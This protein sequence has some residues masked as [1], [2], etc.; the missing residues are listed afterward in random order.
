MNRL[1][2]RTTLAAIC[3]VAV[4]G[5]AIA[6]EPASL[7]TVR[8]FE[9]AF[10]AVSE[11][12]Q[13]SVVLLEVH[14]STTG[15]VRSLP[16]ADFFPVEGLGSGFIIDD[17]GT[18]LTNHHVIEGADRIDVTLH[19]GRQLRAVPVAS[20]PESDVGVVRLVDPPS[21]LPVAELGDSG[22]LRI[23]QFAIAVGAPLGY[24]RSVTYGHISGLHRT[25]VGQHQMGP[26]AAPGFESLII[27]DFIQVDTPI[28]PG[29]S[30]GPVVDLDG[31][32][33]GINTAIASAPGGGLGFA[34]P[35]DLAMRI[36]RQLEA[37]EVTVGWLG[38]RMSDNN[39]SLDEVWGRSI[40]QGALIQEVFDGSPA[41]RADLKPDDVVVG[42][43]GRKIRSEFDLQSAVRI[44]PTDEPLEIAVWRTERGDD[45]LKTYTVVLDG[46]P[47]GLREAP[48]SMKGESGSN[49]DVAY[50]ARE[51][52][53]HVDTERNKLVVKRVDPGSLAADAEIKEGDVLVE[54]DS[55]S[56]DDVRSFRQSLQGGSKRFLSLVVER[57][58]ERVFLGI[59]RP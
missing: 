45:V 33:I 42:F 26:F 1:L 6:T 14:S 32:V 24:A 31:R 56:I 53:L 28:N 30:G 40:G 13:P 27:Q 22:D 10:I 38:V 7:D 46:R 11:K 18:I 51:I 54:I 9:S 2:A 29:N 3:V 50:L 20:S 58:G 52:G 39:P 37:G 34:I 57:D 15:G 23:G 12:V 49:A 47:L 4:A 25:D 5:S 43:A 21:D 48:P 41:S 19:D 8:A 16:G 35:I 44:S 17:R 59:E 36:A 55:V